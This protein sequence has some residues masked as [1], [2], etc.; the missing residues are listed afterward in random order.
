MCKMSEREEEKNIW[1]KKKPKKFLRVHEHICNLF[2]CR[3]SARFTTFDNNLRMYSLALCKRRIFFS[4]FLHNKMNFSTEHKNFCSTSSEKD[5]NFLV[6]LANETKSAEK[7]TCYTRASFTA[8]DEGRSFVSKV[9]IFFDEIWIYELYA[10][11]FSYQTTQ[12][13]NLWWNSFCWFYSIFWV[14]VRFSFP[15][16]DL[17]SPQINIFGN[18]WNWKAFIVQKKPND[19]FKSVRNFSFP[20]LNWKKIESMVKWHRIRV[21]TRRFSQHWPR[22]WS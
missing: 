13:F 21:F 10:A 11:F 2:F 14:C 22:S 16:R 17:V 7:K 18:D 15:W 6:C 5:S 19:I 12:Y 4:F 3:Q 9:W 20:F 8:H 1:K